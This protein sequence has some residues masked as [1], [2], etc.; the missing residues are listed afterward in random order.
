MDPK[1]ISSLRRMANATGQELVSSRRLLLRSRLPRSAS[2]GVVPAELLKLTDVCYKDS[3]SLD[4]AVSC[5]RL[6]QRVCKFAFMT[7][8]YWLLEPRTTLCLSFFQ[9]SVHPVRGV[10][11]FETDSHFKTAVILFLLLL[12]SSQTEVHCFSA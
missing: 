2:Y 11:S 7:A 3:T 12:L 10:F 8:V 1:A 6:R 4:L 9:T 5:G